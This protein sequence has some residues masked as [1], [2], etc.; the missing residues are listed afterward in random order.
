MS[1]TPRNLDDLVAEARKHLV[2][3][4]HDATYDWESLDRALEVRGAARTFASL[5]RA[6]QSGARWAALSG[7]ALAAA[8]AAVLFLR[9]SPPAIRA[10]AAA[11]QQ[12]AASVASAPDDGF[13]IVSSRGELRGVSSPIH[14]GDRIETGANEV[15]F[16]S[17][18]PSEPARQ[19]VAWRVEAHSRLV[20]ASARAPLG[21]TLENGAVEADV[22]RVSQ[23]EAFVVD[24]GSVRVAVKGTHL[25][26]AR[27]G[28][29]ATIDLTEGTIAIGAIPEAGLTTGKL[30]TAPAHVEIDLLHPAELRIVTASEAVRSEASAPALRVAPPARAG[31]RPVVASPTPSPALP[32]LPIAPASSAAPAASPVAAVA[33]RAPTVAPENR[34]PEE[35]V[36]AAVRACIDANVPSGPVRV[37]INTTLTLDMDSNGGIARARF[38]PP[39]SPEVQRCASASIYKTRFPGSTTE[40]ISIA[41]ER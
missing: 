22:A 12:I 6:S 18:S 19:S 33:A 3:E 41:A 8:A 10:G 37:V 30:V 28:D 11:T 13:R 7:V 27:S 39:L 34:H 16:I 5:G 36:R 15:S 24:V 29:R 17:H 26:V 32:L 1:I 2:P 20:V 21:L 40:R 4:T 35:I 23:G 9:P 38:E 14:L 25:R 31:D